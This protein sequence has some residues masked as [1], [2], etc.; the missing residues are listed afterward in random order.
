VIALVL[1][2]AVGCEQI[3]SRVS[4]GEESESAAMPAVSVAVAPRT[5]TALGRL[6]P[7]DGL[8][9]LAGPSDFSVVIAELLVEKG[10][11]VR[12]GQVL[13]F[14]DTLEMRHA[15]VDRLE[16]ELAQSQRDLARNVKLHQGKILAQARLESWQTQVRMHA[17]LL[18]RARAEL[19]RSRV[20]SPIDGEVIEIHTYP[21]ERVGVDG[22][23]ELGRT[24]EMV[25]IAEVYETDIGR[26]RKG[27]RARVTSPAL[28]GPLDGTVE[29]IK[30]KVGKMD[31]L[32]TD[33][34]AKT[35]ARV[36]EVEIHLDEGDRAAGLTYL[37][38]EVTITPE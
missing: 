13:A 19:A 7:R 28:S 17:A 9:Q 26:V 34:A 6:E 38:V 36:V 35:D 33:P 5:I 12:A 16:A 15:D 14:L 11:R 10:D 3:E 30:P 20:T 1:L 37:Q 24:D 27:Q 21:G 4:A 18:A 31:V 8:M 32:G 23:L 22:I 2:G 29:W 25:A